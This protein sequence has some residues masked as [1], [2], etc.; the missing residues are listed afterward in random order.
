MAFISDMQ[1]VVQG[2][3]I[4]GIHCM[5]SYLHD[6]EGIPDCKGTAAMER[7]FADG[8]PQ[9]TLTTTGGRS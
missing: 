2:C 3:P 5:A 7:Y 9:Q 4:E 6:M 8:K 1:V